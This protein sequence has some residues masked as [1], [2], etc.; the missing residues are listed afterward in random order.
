MY[1]WLSVSHMVCRR[2]G[3]DAAEDECVVWVPGPVLGA[4]EHPAGGDGV[5]ARLGLV[6]VVDVACGGPAVVTN[7][8]TCISLIIKFI[9]RLYLFGQNTV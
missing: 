4:V 9:Q 8:P 7:K 1:F 6:S 5:G 3:C 2:S